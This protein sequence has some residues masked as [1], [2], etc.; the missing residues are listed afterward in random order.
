MTLSQDWLARLAEL[1]DAR[2]PAALVVVTGVEGSVP[3]EAGARM[4]VA[5]GKLVWEYVNP[6]VMGKV[7]LKKLEKWN[8]LPPPRANAFFRAHKYAPDYPAFAGRDLAPKS[9]L[10]EAVS[11]GNAPATAA[12]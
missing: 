11:A 3:R 1:R 12:P 7:K 5:D 8:A 10:E 9:E 2:R 6:D 4:I